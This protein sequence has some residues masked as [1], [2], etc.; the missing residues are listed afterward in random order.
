M[1]ASKKNY[2]VGTIRL[3]TL[4]VFLFVA[5]QTQPVFADSGACCA[6][7]A[8]STEPKNRGYLSTPRGREEFP[9]LTRPGAVL[10]QRPVAKPAG[11][12]NR[13]LANSPRYREEHP[14][15]LRPEGTYV[16]T[17]RSTVP[18]EV[19]KNTAFAASP[20]AREEFPALQRT[21]PLF[22]SQKIQIAPFK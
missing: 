22:N 21:P 7:T 12:S 8:A 6:A 11:V 15:L 2:L 10:Q 3:S 14:E 9:W 18:P 17:T 20:R 4:S 13:A 16:L 19:T 5:V 1:K